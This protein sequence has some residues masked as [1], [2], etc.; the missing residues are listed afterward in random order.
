MSSSENNL[1]T[2]TSHNVPSGKG[3]KFGIV[4]AEWNHEITTSLAEG[5]K[6][7]LL[8]HHVKEDD[9]TEIDVPGSFELPMGAKI[10]LS[11]ESFDAVV[12]IGCVITGETKH[13]EYISNSVASSISQLG[14]L[15]GT[16]VIFGVLTPKSME[17]ALDR[18]GGKHGNKGIEAAVAAIKMAAL[19]KF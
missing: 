12:C 3:L 18:A 11:K 15:S 14:I 8:E 5:C 16:P 19:R 6:S 9:I 10:L 2:V 1:S 7:F 4:R 13:D 17:Q